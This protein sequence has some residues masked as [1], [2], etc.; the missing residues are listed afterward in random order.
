M[1]TDICSAEPD[2]DIPDERIRTFLLDGTMRT[3]HFPRRM[4]IGNIAERMVEIGRTS[5]ISIT[6]SPDR[7][8]DVVITTD[9]NEENENKDM[10]Y[11]N[12]LC[13]Q[14]VDAFRIPKV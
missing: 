4:G 9:V 11:L 8:G 10:V 13:H 7:S 14:T 5:G 2:A 6:L 3:L 1:T 12:S